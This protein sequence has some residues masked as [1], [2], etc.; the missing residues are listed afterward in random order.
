MPRSDEEARDDASDHVPDYV[1]LQ[2]MGLPNQQ[3]FSIW[4]TP[5]PSC[6][7]QYQ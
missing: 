6:Y 5:A 3:A 4:C 7:S 2:E 1:K